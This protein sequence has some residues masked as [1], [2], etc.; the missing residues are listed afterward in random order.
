MLQIKDNMM[1]VVPQVMDYG[2]VVKLLGSDG[3][4]KVW[5]SVLNLG[6]VQQDIVV[7]IVG[8]QFV[9]MILI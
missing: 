7:M 3:K 1:I 4:G 5:H 2:M 6:M 8:N 9:K